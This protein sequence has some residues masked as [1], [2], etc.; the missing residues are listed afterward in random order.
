METLLLS[1]ILS[2]K[3]R[4]VAA[5]VAM[6]LI[7]TSMLDQTARGFPD[8][9]KSSWLSRWIYANLAIVAM[10][11]LQHSQSFMASCLVL[12]YKLL[13]LTM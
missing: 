5:D 8:A 11:A 3:G 7:A 2:S 10:L 6:M 9:K 13:T 1:P 12:S 4:S